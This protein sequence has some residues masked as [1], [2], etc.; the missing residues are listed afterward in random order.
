MRYA[1]ACLLLPL[2]C[3]APAAAD[4][5]TLPSTYS[6]DPLTG[7]RVRQY[8]PV[9]APTAPV[10]ANY[11]SSGYTHTRSTLNFGPSADN[12]HRVER[13]GEPV[14]PYGEWQRPY[15]PYSVP[16]PYWGEPY[17]GLNLN[18]GGR[19]Y[20]GPRPGRGHQGGAAAVEGAR[21]VPARDSQ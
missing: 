17:G 13:W 20:R 19:G 7:E 3:A 21:D 4:W 10:V 11:R 8:Q 5:L 2:L 6:H 12:Y 9:D 15:R 18:F 16:Y 14:R 1:F